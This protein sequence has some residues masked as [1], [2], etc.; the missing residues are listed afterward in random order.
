MVRTRLSHDPLAN[1][2]LEH[3]RHRRPERVVDIRSEP[4]D[5][6]LRAD[7][8]GQV[9]NDL[10]RSTIGQCCQIRFERISL[11]HLEPAGIMRSYLGQD[12]QAAGIALH[13]DD[14]RG[15]LG[16]QG[17]REPT[18]ARTDLEHGEALERARRP[19]D[20]GGQVEVEQEILSE[21]LFRRQPV[22]GND[23][24]QRWKAVG[25]GG[26]QTPLNA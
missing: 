25:G 8:V 16:Q 6:Q 18:R 4:V 9:G 2:L 22:R 17:P 21:R 12:W 15:A 3:Q 26:H 24:A 7:I 10:G 1:F 19:G 5:Q 11:H 13:R 14:A 23:I 20:L